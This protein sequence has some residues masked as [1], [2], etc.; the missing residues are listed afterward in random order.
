MFCNR[1]NFIPL[2]IF[3]IVFLP[4]SV[5]AQ[6]PG[7]GLNI[8]VGGFTNPVN[9]TNAGD[10]SGRLFIVEQAGAIKIVKNGVLQV[11]PFLDISDRVLSGGEQGLLSVVFPFGYA[12][13]GYFYV[14]YTRNTDGT[15]VVSR[16]RVTTNPDIADPATEEII[17]TIEQP[18][19]NHN[20]GQLAFSP[21]D[22]YLYIGMGDGGS[23][24]DPNNYA[25]N[26]NVLPGNKKLLG[27]LLRIDVESGATPYAI[28]V[29]N[30]LLKGTRSE[31]W[32]L[33]LRNPW[34]FS[35]DRITA[36]LYIG[37][38]G[39]A[40]R[41]EIDFQPSSSAG[42][43]N[44]GWHIL[45]G[46]LCFNPLSGCIPPKNY[47]P[48]I[49]EY[50][51]SAGCSVTGGFVYRGSEFS[52]L[53]GIYFY[54]DF[55]TGKIWGLKRNG[56]FWKKVL[57]F[58]TPLQISSFGEG[59]DG[60]IYVA[61]YATGNIYKII[62]AV[63]VISPNGGEVI[64]SGA[65]FP[66]QWEASSEATKFDLMLSFDNGQTWRPIAN[67]VAGTSY[68][69][70]VPKP[71]G[72]QKKCLVKVIGYDASD[73][74]VGSDKSDSP[75]TIEVIKLDAPSDPGI[76]MTSGGTYLI[77]WATNGIRRTVARTRL[78]FTK[79][80]GANWD[81]KIATLADNPGSY[82]WTVP[83]VKTTRTQCKIKVELKDEGGIV[84]GQDISDNNFTINPAP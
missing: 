35:F 13:K 14:N 58:N 5:E 4:L 75:F 73:V 66:I 6:L 45:E 65:T 47:S 49:I 16:F 68:P 21:K 43:E 17:L 26:L 41:E 81:N 27:K 70:T 3:V 62:Q 10:S 74:K 33:G 84:L 53:N 32:A 78:T 28:P 50:N 40:T 12:S 39:Q 63:K 77:E 80:G 19:A 34:R 25:Q 36:D 24:G 7:I 54:G 56:G 11:I 57:R 59:E 72:N 22:G 8:Y 15:T 9:I 44:Y 76:S 29:D 1:I 31:I 2:L 30:P 51:H 23:G 83:A 52:L 37:D 42:A 67:D 48:P 69:W 79:D 82:L 20:G 61:D 38:V 55:C 18:F 71:L 46:S 60:S 64:S